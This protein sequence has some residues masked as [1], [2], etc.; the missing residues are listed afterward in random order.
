M[1]KP[2]I[3][4]F[5][6]SRVLEKAQQLKANGL[7]SAALELL[8][9]NSIEFAFYDYFIEQRPPAPREHRGRFKKK[10]IKGAP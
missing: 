8:Q 1:M 6:P 2:E 7:Y 5:A 9:R 10:V 3:R 4:T